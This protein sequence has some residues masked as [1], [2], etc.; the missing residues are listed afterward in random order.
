MMT[1]RMLDHADSSKT[2]N[3]YLAASFNTKISRNEEEPK[4]FTSS[5]AAP[6][7]SECYKNE[8]R[9]PFPI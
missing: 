5:L 7:F 6:H 2:D 1:A 9:P 3:L 4:Y 8:E